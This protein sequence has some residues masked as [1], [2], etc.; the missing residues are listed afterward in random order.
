MNLGR[1]VG[2]V[3]ATRKE[4]RLQGFKLQVV[5]SVDLEGQ[6]TGGFQIA[7]DAAPHG[8]D[9]IY[10]PGVC[11][12]L[13][14]HDELPFTKMGQQNRCARRQQDRR[15]EVVG[16]S[17]GGLG[18]QVGCRRCDDDGGLLIGQIDVANLRMVP[19]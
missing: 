12:F 8:H 11:F 13:P 19:F 1:V 5:E 3:V 10:E 18:E 15:Q 14:G 2:T 17:G 9:T 7:V 16:D 4:E 6:P